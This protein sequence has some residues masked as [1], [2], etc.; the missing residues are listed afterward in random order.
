MGDREMK[1]EKGVLITA[2]IIIVADLHGVTRVVRIR[3]NN[4]SSRV[5]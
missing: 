4:P 3:M 5:I 1:M 2:C